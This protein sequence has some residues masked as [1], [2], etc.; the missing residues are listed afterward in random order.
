MVQ[1]EDFWLRI[2]NQES[3]DSW[4]LDFDM[5]ELL[6][7]ELRKCQWK[8]IPA[9]KTKSVIE[10]EANQFKTRSF[11]Q[12]VSHFVWSDISI[13]D[14]IHKSLLFLGDKLGSVS[15][16]EVTLNPDDQ[17]R[18][19]EF[20]Q[21]FSPNGGSLTCLNFEDCDKKNQRLL[22][23][24]HLNGQARL[25]VIKWTGK[26]NV[27]IENHGFVWDKEDRIPVNKVKLLTK[28]K[29]I[30]TFAVLKGQYLLVRKFKMDDK[31]LKLIS[32]KVLA[33]DLV[34]KIVDI[35]R[36]TDQSWLITG[37]SGQTSI[38]RLDEKYEFSLEDEPLLEDSERYRCLSVSASPSSCIFAFLQTVNVVHDHLVCRSPSKIVFKTPLQLN[39]N[40]LELPVNQLGHIDCLEA[41]RCWGINTLNSGIDW[42]KC[43]SKLQSNKKY[44]LWFIQFFQNI[45][46]NQNHLT[47]LQNLEEE[48]RC[49]V[50]KEHSLNLIA[51]LKSTNPKDPTIPSL[52]QFLSKMKSKTTSNAKSALTCVICD[53]SEDM[54]KWS[55]DCVTCT[56]GHQWP[57]CVISLRACDSP[58]PLRCRGCNAL[59]NSEWSNRLCSLCGNKLVKSDL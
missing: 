42:K 14:G 11:A 31:D 24:G 34:P 6:N 2:Y 57:R 46:K 27:N 47:E 20:Q 4:R 45:V 58:M 39:S 21:Y 44:Q 5:S 28:E 50:L 1:T 7:S 19:I 38:L 54:S 17:D 22:I 35:N 10:N 52:N 53:Q 25:S 40:Q 8:S 56:E 43:I 51:N 36:I 13:V 48:I 3:N 18:K 26:G 23:S 16:W 30:L 12:T 49:D 59:A 29:N 15:V 55:S 33:C 32:H 41:V 37:E 9:I